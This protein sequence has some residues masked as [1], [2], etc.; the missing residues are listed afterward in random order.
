MSIDIDLH[1]W[2]PGKA[3][4]RWM[5]FLDMSPEDRE[6]A[7]PEEQVEAVL[8]IMN[9]PDAPAE[10]RAGR[11]AALDLAFG[12]VGE[13]LRIENT[14]TFEPFMRF[15]LTVFVD[16]DSQSNKAPSYRLLFENFGGILNINEETMRHIIFDEFDARPTERLRTALYPIEMPKDY[17]AQKK[18]TEAVIA[19]WQH[20]SPFLR[21]AQE[22]GSWKEEA[23]VIEAVN[24]EVDDPQLLKRAIRHEKWL[25]EAGC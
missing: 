18:I 1:I 17:A 16:L 13:P 3:D 24:R 11:I 4:D 2:N 20:L 23:F 14:A 10:W 19:F 22:A 8:K 21:K 9:Q 5:D 15:L 7:E 12:Q 25:H 6:N